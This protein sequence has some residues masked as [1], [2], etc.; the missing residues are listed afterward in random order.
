MTVL[1]IFPSDN[2]YYHT[3]KLSSDVHMHK[4]YS[5]LHCILQVRSALKRTCDETAAINGKRIS[6]QT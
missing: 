5:Q 1:I 3:E 4:T 2:Y 6:Q